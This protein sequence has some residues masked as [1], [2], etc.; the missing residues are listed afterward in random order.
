MIRTL[1]IAAVLGLVLLP[2]HAAEQEVVPLQ[3]NPFVAPKALEPPVA[4]VAPRRYA[5]PE[6]EPE[7]EPQFGLRAVLSAGSDSLANI[8]GS[9]LG[10]GQTIDGYRLVAIREH[11]V[12]LKRRGKRIVLDLFEDAEEAVRQ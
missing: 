7:P 10:V 11:Q 3:R 12:V 4:A 6:P 1:K 8:D 5:E 9:I 2:V